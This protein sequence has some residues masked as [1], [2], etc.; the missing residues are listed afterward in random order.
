MEM[1]EKDTSQTKP[2][3]LPILIA[4]VLFGGLSQ[5]GNIGGQNIDSELL[6]RGYVDKN[7]N[8]LKGDHVFFATITYVAPEESI[9]ILN[10]NFNKNVS[11]T[12]RTEF[13]RN[14]EVSANLLPNHQS[15]KNKYYKGQTVK[16]KYS[17]DRGTILMSIIPVDNN[18]SSVD[19][20]LPPDAKFY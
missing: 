15:L 7:G 12:L 10:T 17:E 13:D 14:I 16:V 2:S 11:F 19:F 18:F 8:P 3:S 6:R 4:A 5:I 9:N 1:L 20:K